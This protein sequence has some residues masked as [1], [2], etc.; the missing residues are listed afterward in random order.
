M[1]NFIV[2]LY[3]N[4]LMKKYLH[5]VYVL[6]FM[7][8]TPMRMVAIGWTP[9]DGGLVL[10]LEQGD[11]FLLSVW[12]D[13]DG[14]GVE[15][16][17]EEFFVENY[18]RYTGGYFNYASGSYLKLI[19]QEAGATEPSEMSIWSVGAPLERGNYALGGIVY[20]IWND[21]KT[22]KTGKNTNYQFLGDLTSDYNDAN[23][24]DAVFVLPTDRVGVVSF[25]PNNTLGRN[26]ADTLDKAGVNVKGRF[27]GHLGT[28]F[29]GMHYREVY[30]LEIPR[31]NQ[32]RAY[33]NAA[34]VTFN[35]TLSQKSWSNGQI[36]CDPG[37]AAYAYADDKHKPTTRTVFRIYMLDDPINSCGSYFFATDVQNKNKKYRKSETMNDST[38]ARKIYTWDRFYCMEHVGDASSKIYKSGYMNVPAGATSKDDST[39]YFVGKHDTYVNDA[40]KATM[41][42]NDAGTAVSQFKYIDSLRIFALKDSLQPNGK[43]FIAPAGA[44]GRMVVDTTS[45]K[46]N[47][48]VAF[49]P[50]GYFFQTNSGTNVNMRQVDDS[51][52]MVDEMWYIDPAYMALQARIMLY[53][54]AE[55]NA[56]DAGAAIEGWSVYVKATDIPVVGGGTASGKYGWA[57]IHTNRAAQNGG[58]EF[59]AA[60]QTKHVHYDNNGHFGAA[61]PDQYPEVGKTK[62]AVQAPRLIQGY[63]FICWTNIPDTT[64]GSFTKYHPGDSVDL[65]TIPLVDGKRIL[66]LYAQAKYTG[67]IHVA[68]SFMKDG[69]RYFLTHPG[70]APRYASIRH[71]EDWVNVWQGMADVNNSDPNYISTYKIIGKETVCAECE[72]DEYVLDPRSET[73]KGAVDSLVFYENFHPENEEYIGLY[74]TSPSYIIANNTW[75][76]LFTSSNGWPTPA[77]A[78]VSSTQLASDSYLER[79]G[80]GVITR[81]TRTETPKDPDP[82]AALLPANIQYNSVSSVF[83]GVAEAGT[84]FMI[85]GVGVVDEHYI[86]L[87]DTSAVWRDTIE[88]GFHE[89]VQT[90][91]D[92]WSKLIGKQ[93]LAQMKVGDDTIYFHPNRDKIINDPNELYLSQ[94]FRVTQLFSF[95]QD[96]RVTSIP[97]ENQVSMEATSNYWHYNIISG[98]SSPIDIKDARGNYV[99]VVDTFR[100]ELSHGN[101]S[102]IKKY[103]GRWADDAP[104]MY[105]SGTSR[106]RDI[107]VR[108]KTYHYEPEESYLVLTPTQDLYVFNPLRGNSHQLDFSL[109]KVTTQRLVDV[110]GN[111]VRLD[112]VSIEDV[113]SQ[114]RLGPSSCSFGT[115]TTGKFAVVEGGTS[116]DHVTLQTTSENK[117][118]VTR[119]TLV[120]TTNVTIAEDKTYNDVTVRVPLLQTPLEADELIWSVE[121]NNQRYFIMAGSSGW[122]FRRYNYKSDDQTLYKLNNNNVHLVIGSNAGDNSDGKYLT[123]W[124]YTYN[125]SDSTQLSLTTEYGID[126][127]INIVNDTARISGTA[128]CYFTYRYVDVHVNAN[129]NEEEVVRLKYLNDKWLKFSITGGV[130]HLT[131]VADSLEGSVFSW[132]YLQREYDLTDAGTYP[133]RNE[134]TFGYNSGSAVTFQTRYKAFKRFSTL[135]GNRQTYLARETEDVVANLVN[136]ELEWRTDTLIEIIPDGRAFDADASSGLYISGRNKTTLQTTIR[137]TSATSPLNVTI[138]GKYVDIVDTLHF[139]ISLRDGAPEYRFFGQWSWMKSLDDAELKL[140]L[141]RKTYHTDPYD[142]IVCLV[143]ND[144]GTYTFPSKIEGTVTHTF[145]LSSEWR[146]GAHVLNVDNEVAAVVSPTRTNVTTSGGMDLSSPAKAEIRLVDEYG[147]TPDW[148]AITGKTATTLT[149]QCLKDGIRSPRSA[150]IYLAY[151]LMIDDDGDDKTP[152]VMRFVNYRMTITQ[153]SYFNYADN[154]HLV[155]SKGAS[156]DSIKDGMQQVHENKRILYYYPDQDVELPVREVHFFGWWR[157]YREGTDEYGT[158]VGDQDV[159][160]SLWRKMPTNTGGKYNYPFRRIGNKVPVDPEDPESDSVLVTMGRYTVFHYRSKDYPNVRLSP[161]LSTVMVAPPDTMHTGVNRGKPATLTYAVDISN[162]YDNLPM[163]L[164]QKNQV[165]TARMDTMQ[166]I[167]EPTLSLREVFELRPWTEMAD[168]MD[169]YKTLIPGNGK[170]PNDKYMEDHVV[171]API[172]NRLLLKTEQRYN[173]ANVTSQGHSESLLGYYMHDDNWSSM[174]AEKDEDG[175]SRQDSMIWCGGWDADCVWYTYN[176]TTQEYTECTHKITESDDFL[177]VPAKGSISEGNE[178]D[179]VYYCLRARSWKTTFADDD[180]EDELIEGEETEDGDYMFNI[181]RYKII[182]HD[183]SKY[184]PLPETKKQGVNKALITNEEIEQRYEILEKLNFDYNQPGRAFVVYPHPLPW[185]DASYGYTYPETASLP[186]NRLHDQTALPNFGEYGLINRIP[187]ASHWSSGTTYWHPMEQHGGAE[188]GYMIYCDGMSSA[189]QVAA[190][191]LD[192]TLCD[193]QKMFFSAYVANPYIS[194]ETKYARPNFTFSVQGRVDDRSEWADITSYMTGDL[195]PSDKWYQIYFPIIDVEEGMDYTQFRIK[196]FNMASN[197]DGNDFIIDD[198]CIFA[199]KPPLLAYQ[200][201]TVCKEHGDESSDTHVILRLDYGG[202]TGEGYNGRKVYYTVKQ[203]DT[204]KDTTF[205]PMSGGGYLEQEIHKGKDETTADTICGKIFIPA[206]DYEPADEDSIYANLSEFIVRYDS[207]S[208]SD[209]YDT[210]Q[211]GYIYEVLEGSIRPVKYI[212]HNA[213][214]PVE[215]E[216]TV[217]MS[218]NYTGLLSSICGM[219]SRLNVTDRMVL[220]IDGEEQP[221]MEVSGMCANATYELGLHVKGSMYVDSVAPIELTGTCYNDWLLYGDTTEAGSKARYGYKYSDIVKV[222]KDI[223]R[224]EPSSGSRNRNQFAT[225]FSAV[226]R[227]EMDRIQKNES[228]VE[229]DTTDSP[230]DIL[231]HLVENGFLILYKS[232]MTVNVQANDSVEYVIFP[233]SGT[234]TDA[235]HST[236][237]DVCTLPIYVKLVPKADTKV[238]LILGGDGITRKPTDAD[239]PVV[240][241]MDEMQ[242]NSDSIFVKIDSIMTDPLAGGVAIDSIYLYSCNDPEFRPGVHKLEFVPDREYSYTGGDN[243]GYYVKNDS[244]RL[245]PAPSTNYQM[246]GGY[247]YTF[248]ITLRSRSGDGPR[249]DAGGCSFGKVPFTIGVVPSYLRWDPQS[250]DDN[251]WNN[252]DNWIGITQSNEPISE[253]ARFAPLSSTYVVIPPL[254][255]TLPYPTLPELPVAPVDSIQEV[256]FM[257]NKCS[258]IRFIAGAAM[259]QQ[260]RMRYEQ[261]IVDLSLPH[262]KW[263]FRTSPVA[264]MISG[265]LFMAQ[266]DIN[267][268]T[269]PWEVGAFDAN[270]RNYRTGT[271]SFWL[272][273]FNQSVIHQGSGSMTDTTHINQENWSQVTNGLTHPLPAG[274]GWA[275]YTRTPKNNNATVRLPKNDNIY[276]YYNQYGD[277]MYDLYEPNLQ[278]LR[279]TVAGG[280]GAGKLLF[281]PDPSKGQSYTLTNTTADTIFIFGNPT[282]GYIDIWGFLDDNRTKLVQQFKTINEKDASLWPV[283]RASVLAE[284]NRLSNTDRYLPPMHAIAL[285]ATGAPVTTLTLNLDS[286]RIVTD[287]VP[288]A[289][290]ASPIRRSGA[291]VLSKGIMRIT[292]TNDVDERCTTHLLL[293][294]GYHKEVRAGEDALLTTINIEKYTVTGAPA[295]PFNIYALEG[296]SALSINLLDSI[297]NVPVS[298]MMTENLISAFEPITN[299]WF[300]G[301]NNISEPL[302]LYDALTDT[303]RPIMDGVCIRIETPQVNNLAR[304]YIRRRGYTSSTGDDTPTGLGI[305]GAE[306]EQAVKFIQNGQVF[307]MRNGHIYSVV[308]QKVR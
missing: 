291:P 211:V 202:I 177:N 179:T 71:F 188:N 21:G 305:I 116:L 143:A 235:L 201:S 126:K 73:M 161:P 238:P 66:H 89:G 111:F 110:E 163:S 253:E 240:L 124:K 169:H 11:R 121:Y 87:P 38:P 302:V 17:G 182:Y 236:R 164:S 218:L 279:A 50:K 295:T 147:N 187:E 74:Y 301:V 190:L 196:I 215:N 153:P 68:I 176:P 150:Y 193:G 72:S 293:G 206:K 261:A 226:S 175:W 136:P 132:T 237:V 280:V 77:R 134:A 186:H 94:D 229:L 156:G 246:R 24:C 52:W 58:M 172:G 91:E 286:T 225:S 307:I 260:Q 251:R 165:D 297:V 256:G 277:K 233:I 40:N 290:A 67:S 232:T 275:V 42:L 78:C 7:L 151:V 292:A 5:I 9:T 57:R 157:W 154:Q 16:P 191:H 98:L 92:V 234:G 269:T 230:Y 118:G 114:L 199:T 33:T 43:P 200:A 99:D 117:T 220:A 167:P 75:A 3:K 80:E 97:A 135:L 104:G 56:S 282:M 108:T 254:A 273:M 144:E 259:N 61:V 138:G 41:K 160:D 60:D 148:C 62:V 28:G 223:L 288:D 36:K 208:A 105:F 266:A 115:A 22:L 51:T 185:A 155:H 267:W 82:S 212:I 69:Q 207:T 13:K 195:E 158:D 30:W 23:A 252:P 149:V 271:G 125:E 46:Q 95:I 123:P 39:F 152:D 131:L 101:I 278:A 274:L 107:I 45:T 6:A 262:D 221:K 109:T 127:Y 217:H 162:Y 14:D 216:Y 294:Q 242:A 178:F 304:Y 247:R 1:R 139:K 239:M 8:L 113:T 168:T 63:E 93:L 183:N 241:L 180:D 88:F 59:V 281:N 210:V 227:K 120:V 119:D 44:Y 32:P 102:K 189:G 15:D 79:N 55:F 85:S 170:Y 35:R 76:G 106:V 64:K 100:I 83:D 205:L 19:P 276:Y 184:G 142:S 289:P 203:V 112:T 255:D 244:I 284:P 130:G 122:I 198:M 137:P 308:G 272:S 86:I 270:G 285:T 90:R 214:M 81:Y 10:N 20:T 145:T 26:A 31:G 48:A 171:M 84:D 166:A 249:V 243:T 25:D 49:E 129:A 213:D 37:H 283:T 192:T 65:S 128:P 265:D 250:S 29:L 70:V 263:A 257:Y 140:P 103:Y 146:K 96:S 296:N 54:G 173:K 141:I 303:E 159:P 53:T 300:S 133:S 298:F 258:Y 27:N 197:W 231:K 47:L 287:T 34:L 224:Y 222:I 245:R 248:V 2:N 228:K 12:V 181:C 306:E 219:T 299:L 4:L 174:S 209:K 194:K 18:N 264:G 204:E 268:E